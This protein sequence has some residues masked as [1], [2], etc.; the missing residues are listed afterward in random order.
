MV[1]R[2]LA[3]TAVLVG[4]GLAGVACGDPADLVSGNVFAVINVY[5][6]VNSEAGDPVP[7]ADIVGVGYYNS[8]CTG[9]PGSNF[10][11]GATTTLGTYEGVAGVGPLTEKELPLDGCIKLYAFPEFGTELG[12]DSAILDSLYLTELLAVD[13]DTLEVNFILR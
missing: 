7:F 10:T 4:I 1:R 8:T 12:V 13:A 5:G 9:S 3:A 11:T 2:F 6:T